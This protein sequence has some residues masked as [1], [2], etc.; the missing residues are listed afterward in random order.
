MKIQRMPRSALLTLRQTRNAILQVI[1]RLSV[2][3]IFD[4][5]SKLRRLTIKMSI[6]YKNGSI[7]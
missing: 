3:K 5:A 2:R 1:L 4:T 7:Y 6:C